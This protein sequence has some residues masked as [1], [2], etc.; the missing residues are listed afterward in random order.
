MRKGLFIAGLLVVLIG[1]LAVSQASLNIAPRAI[2]E[3]GN[4]VVYLFDNETGATQSTIVLVFSGSVGL[5]PT[6]VLAIGGD[7]AVIH[8][9]G[10]GALV[11]IDVNVL[12]GGT[13]EIALTGDNAGASIEQ[14]WWSQ[15]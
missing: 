12:A 2:L 5:Q 1:V 9:W 15:N 10:G 3:M 4:G 13:V 6:D 14:A 8:L 7:A 11:A